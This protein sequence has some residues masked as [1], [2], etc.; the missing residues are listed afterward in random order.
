MA[1]DPELD[2]TQLLHAAESGDDEARDEVWRAVYDE[3]RAIAHREWWREKNG[4]TLQATALVHEVWV[5]LKC[6]NN[7]WASREQFLGFAAN[8]MRE[9]IADDAI[10]R[11]RLKR[12]GGRKRVDIDKVGFK[13]PAADREPAEIVAVHE[14]IERLAKLNERQAKVIICRYFGGMTI[15]ETAKA[16]CIG[17]RTVQADS[18]IAAAWLRKELASTY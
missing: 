15:D 7:G 1:I 11:V 6:P 8:V 5:R 3:L 14:L 10:R 12:G 2:I 4:R 17:A 16:L 9:I 13:M 18:A